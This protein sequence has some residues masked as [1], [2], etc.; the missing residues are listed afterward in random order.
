MK[1]ACGR[2]DADI[3]TMLSRMFAIEA[4]V[5]RERMGAH[6]RPDKSVENAGRRS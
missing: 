1:I 3:V 6:G 5:S 4:R 2:D